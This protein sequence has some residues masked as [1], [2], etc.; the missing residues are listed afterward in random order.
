MELYTEYKK[1][2]EELQ[3][4]YGDEK[5]KERRLDLLRYQLNEIAQANLKSRE[6]EELEEKRNIIVNSERLH[7]N[8]TEIDE[9]LS[10]QVIDGLSNSIKA[11]EKI[12]EY[13]EIYKEKLIDLKNIYYEIQEHSRDFEN[14]KTQI[15]FDECERDDIEKD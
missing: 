1:K 8:L 14:M 11:L 10:N 2:Q 9:T 15:C 4:N 5:E 13:G 7:I 12:E 3:K 6:D